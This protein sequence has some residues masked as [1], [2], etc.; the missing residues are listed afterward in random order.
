[1][2]RFTDTE[3]WTKDKWFSELDPRYKLF[4]LYICDQCDNV[5]VWEENIRIANLI[6]GFEY[7]LDTLQKEFGDRIHIFEGGSKWWLKSFVE[8]QH[9]D[10]SE[11]STS[12]AVRSYVLLLKKH[13]LWNEYAK[14]T[15]TLQGK[16]KGKGSGK[17]K[18]KAQEYTPEFEL[19]WEAFNR[20]GSKFNAMKRW[21]EIK[22]KPENL[23]DLTKQYLRYCASKDRTQKDGEGWLSGR[24]WE[25]NWSLVEKIDRPN[26]GGL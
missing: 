8:F 12:K 20:K 23:I 14:T 7:S 25:S 17:A 2:K 16:G 11:E 19:W 9:P 21:A 6:I 5:G 1:M 24:M 15:Q 22:D 4:W 10:M 18:A 3:K 13:G 26:N